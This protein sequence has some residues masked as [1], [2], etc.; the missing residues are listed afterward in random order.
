MRGGRRGSCW[1]TARSEVLSGG[2][3]QP[4]AESAPPASDGGLRGPP[5]GA[6]HLSARPFLLCPARPRVAQPRW[7]LRCPRTRRALAHLGT[8]PPAAPSA[9]NVLPSHLFPLLLKRHLILTTTFEAQR[10]LFLRPLA[11]LPCSAFSSLKQFPLSATPLALTVRLRLLEQKLCEDGPRRRLPTPRRWPVEWPSGSPGRGR[12][13]TL[14]A[15]RF[16]AGPSR[17]LVRAALTWP[18]LQARAWH[19]IRED[20]SGPL[21]ELG[22][23]CRNSGA[24]SWEGTRCYSAQCFQER[25]CP[26]L[27]TTREILGS[28]L[29]SES[30]LQSF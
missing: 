10:A 20:L 25:N 15:P 16:C 23:T 30:Q 24:A 19:R 1:D 17:G 11:P 18:S 4:T 12:N 5:D 14:P 2:R 21:G 27:V 3:A 29:W 7:P 8:L 28:R 9:G 22:G 26:R 13:V 6:R